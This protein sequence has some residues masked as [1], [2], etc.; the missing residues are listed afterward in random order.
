MEEPEF[1]GRLE[2]RIC[3]EFS[4]FGDRLRWYWCDGLVPERYDRDGGHWLISG[5]ASIE[6]H[7]R[8][9]RGEHCD[10]GQ[11]PWTFTLIASHAADRMT[12]TGTGC[13]PATA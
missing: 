11:G 2:Y 13:S 3:D 6:T 9:E 8:P 10:P 4:G 1:W 12:S 7:N 5:L